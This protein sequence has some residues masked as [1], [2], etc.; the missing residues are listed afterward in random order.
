MKRTRASGSKSPK[1][2]NQRPLTRAEVMAR[3][4]GKDTTPELA[5]RSALHRAGLRFRLHQKDLPGKPDIVLPSRRVALFV[6]GC[7]WHQHPGCP[8]ARRPSS[9]EEYW[10]RKLDRNMERDVENQEALKL[11][12]WHIVTLWECDIK[13]PENLENAVKYISGL[14]ASK[15]LNKRLPPD[16]PL[17]IPL[18]SSSSTEEVPSKAMERN[19]GHSDS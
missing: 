11:K 14:P 6:H 16:Q 12:G 9:R 8:R 1:D 2:G 15:R 19:S 3:V 4:R 10:N 17:D 18:S 13:N 7:F 5:V